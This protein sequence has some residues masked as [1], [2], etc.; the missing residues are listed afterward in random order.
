MRESHGKPRRRKEENEAEGEE[1][2]VREEDGQDEE[3]SGGEEEG[4]DRDDPAFR[5]WADQWHEAHAGDG[6][7]EDDEDSVPPPRGRLATARSEST[8]DRG[9]SPAGACDT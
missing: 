4:E 2:E 3:E 7:T 9:R 1:E 5:D 6:P 8:R